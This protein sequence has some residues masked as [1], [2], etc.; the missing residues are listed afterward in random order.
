MIPEHDK[1]FIERIKAFGVDA[2]EC[3]PVPF[4]Q[5]GHISDAPK[6]LMLPSQRLI[7]YAWRRRVNANARS[8]SVVGLNHMISSDSVMDD[9]GALLTAPVQL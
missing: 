2:P 7:M 1:D 8:Y 6:T 9:L 5:M 4:G 3:T